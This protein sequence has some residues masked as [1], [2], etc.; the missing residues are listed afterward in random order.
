MSSI[1]TRPTPSNR[2]LLVATAVAL[3][4]GSVL[5][6][7]TVLPAEYGI[8]PTGLGARMGIF[9]MSKQADE[10]LGASVVPATASESPQTGAASESATVIRSEMPYRRDTM[11]LTLAPGEGAEIKASMGAGDAF[12]FQWSASSGDLAVDMHGERVDAAKDEYTSYW[13]EP[14]QRKASGSFTAP[15]EGSHG[16]YWL[17]RGNAPVTVALEVSGFHSKLYRP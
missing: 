4:V 15:F 10:P 13:I 9:A 1:E 8:D 12:V 16:W 11:S 6:I 7:T 14:A 17:N 3:A 5:L 2:Q